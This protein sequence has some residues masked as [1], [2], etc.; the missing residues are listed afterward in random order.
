[1]LQSAQYLLHIKKCLVIHSK[2]CSILHVKICLQCVQFYMSGYD[3]YYK[4]LVLYV[5][6]YSAL[7]IRISNRL[8]LSSLVVSK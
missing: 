8:I 6:M 7:D 4:I 5:R 2:I 3:Q 1:M